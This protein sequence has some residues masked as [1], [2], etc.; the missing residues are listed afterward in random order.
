MELEDVIDH[1]SIGSP[2]TA[3]QCP[4]EVPI[5]DDAFLSVYVFNDCGGLGARGYT[6]IGQYNLKYAMYYIMPTNMSCVYMY[7]K[8]FVTN[9]VKLL[10]CIT[11]TF[12]LV[13]QTGR[14]SRYQ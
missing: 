10:W 4:E 6:A 9:L 1:Y 11:V 5:I 7:R 13:K 14:L 8:A 2:S 3:F 12:V